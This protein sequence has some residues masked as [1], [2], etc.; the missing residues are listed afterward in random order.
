M[1]TGYPKCRIQSTRD[2]DPRLHCVEADGGGH[3]AEYRID[4]IENVML[5]YDT[6]VDP[7]YPWTP[8]EIDPATH[9]MMSGMTNSYMYSE[10]AIDEI[11]DGTWKEI[12]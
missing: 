7:E 11:I 5:I 9:R 1:A 10:D 6:E 8:V 2:E 3:H 4:G 12:N